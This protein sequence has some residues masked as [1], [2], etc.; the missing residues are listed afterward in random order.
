[1]FRGGL[2]LVVVYWSQSGQKTKTLHFSVFFS[3]N[4][5][6]QMSACRTEQ[7]NETSIK[8]KCQNVLVIVENALSYQAVK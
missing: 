1:M 8:V 2:R 7:L 6:M 5:R 4:Q 3:P